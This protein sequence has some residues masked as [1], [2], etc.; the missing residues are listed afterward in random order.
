MSRGIEEIKAVRPGGIVSLGGIAELV[1]CG[2]N[3]DAEFADAGSGDERAIF[4]RF[5]IGEQN[6]VF[7]VALGLPDV[8]GMRLGDIDD[9]E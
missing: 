4:F 8:C 2:G 5:G 6:L 9:E 7:Q 3:F 1:E